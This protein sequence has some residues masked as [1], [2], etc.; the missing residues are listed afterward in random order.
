MKPTKHSWADLPMDAPMPNLERRRV[1]GAQAMISHIRLQRG[2]VLGMHQH[3]NEQFVCV[4]RGRIRFTLG[5]AEGGRKVDVGPGEVLHLPGSTPHAAE[6]LEDTEV[7]DIFSPP[8][9][10]TGIDRR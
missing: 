10:E 7:L 8:S 1:I 4:L 3:D 6:A 9:A 2:F 5:G